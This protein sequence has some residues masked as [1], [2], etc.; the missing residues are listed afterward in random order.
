M[1]HKDIMIAQRV[2]DMS[3][4]DVTTCKQIPHNSGLHAS[5]LMHS[6][7]LIWI[8]KMKCGCLDYM[9]GAAAMCIDN[10]NVL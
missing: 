3:H 8:H 10:A 1:L 6:I 7:V 5:S 4:D 2:S 9:S